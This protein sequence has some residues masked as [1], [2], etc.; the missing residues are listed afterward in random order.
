MEIS[1]NRGPHFFMD[2]LA[3]LE[4]QPFGDGDGRYKRN[5]DF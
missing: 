5:W 4:F 3:D 1:T 2:Q